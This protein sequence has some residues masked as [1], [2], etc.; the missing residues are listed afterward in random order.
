[1]LIGDTKQ[2]LLFFFRFVWKLIKGCFFFFLFSNDYRS[3]LENT[4]RCLHRHRRF[5]ILSRRRR[6]KRDYKFQTKVS[7]WLPSKC[8]NRGQSTVGVDPLAP[9]IYCSYPN[10]II[11]DRRD[12]FS[13]STFPAF[14]PTVSALSDSSSYLSPLHAV[15]I[16][17]PL[18]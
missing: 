17:R 2:I 9:K 6:V 16:P 18:K 14:V 5:V 3:S 12:S 15:A 10:P 1:M 11:F 13:P 8:G 7:P 4:L